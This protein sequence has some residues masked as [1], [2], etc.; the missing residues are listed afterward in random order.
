MSSSEGSGRYYIY[1]GIGVRKLSVKE[2]FKIMGFPD[3]YIFH[4]KT[5][6]N[7]CQIGNA[8]SPVIINNI[9][10]ELCSQNFIQN[11]LV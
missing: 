10:N 5:N 1:D 9:Y 11:P 4:N 7:Y 6:V 8:V 2:C 3:D